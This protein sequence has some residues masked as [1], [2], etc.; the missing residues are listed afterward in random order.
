MCVRIEKEGGGDWIIYLLIIL[1]QFLIDNFCLLFHWKRICILMIKFFIFWWIIIWF[2]LNV[3]VDVMFSIHTVPISDAGHPK[4]HSLTM[5]VDSKK[6]TKFMILYKPF[7]SYWCLI[8][9]CWISEKGD[10]QKQY[11][12]LI[13]LLM[14]KKKK[15]IFWNILLRI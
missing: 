15:I 5:I 2:N 3:F 9:F 10:R 8:Y 11:L 13:L 1:T 4:R 7:F 14:L 12:V 6:R